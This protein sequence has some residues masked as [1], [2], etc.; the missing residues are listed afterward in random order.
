MTETS[1]QIAS[2]QIGRQEEE[3]V[4]RVMRSGG[5]AQ[6][7]EVTAFEAEFAAALT[8]GATCVAVSSGTTGLHLGLLAAGVG[9]G[10]EVVVPSFSFAATA[11]AVALTGATPVFADVDPR[12]L[13]L[14]AASVKDVLTART[15]GVMP[16]HLYGQAADMTAITELAHQHG[17]DVFEDA[18]QAHGATW[19]GQAVGTFGR[20]GVFSLYPTKNMTSGEGGMVSTTDDAVTERLRL[21]RNQ[22]M[23]V[24]YDNELVGHNGRM[25]DLHAAIGRVQL[26]RLTGFTAARHANAARLTAG[27][28]D[29]RGL[30]LPSVDD[31]ARTVWHQYTVRV[32]DRDRVARTL[33]EEHG[34]GTGVYYPT[35]IHR[36][37]VYDQDLDLPVTEAACREV[38]SLPVHPALTTADVDRVIDGVRT[39][40]SAS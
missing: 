10:D 18:A 32:P 35:P 13:C 39:V 12:T 34:I 6:G 20:F 8:P 31:R 27:L 9:P 21:L 37:R 4:L 14:D 3:A 28:G 5:L 33:A 40:L 36:L 30:M 16:V 25:S 23:K 11:N 24:R 29:Q 7:P 26:G 38:L 15:V 19:Q 2:P 22:G 17:L 1:I